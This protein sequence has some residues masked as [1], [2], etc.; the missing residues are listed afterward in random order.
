MGRAARRRLLHLAG[1]GEQLLDQRALGGFQRRVRARPAGD[2]AKG[3]LNPGLAG[4]LAQRR[5]AG[6]GVLHV[7][8]RVVA[9]LL[10]CQV[11]VQVHGRVV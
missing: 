11:Q 6:V 3:R 10:A 9:G 8:N 4:L 7:V 5:D 1:E 2:R